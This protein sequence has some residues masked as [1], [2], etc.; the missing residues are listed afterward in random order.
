MADPQANQ[1]IE[2]PDNSG[3]GT[4]VRGMV[5]KG[6]TQKHVEETPPKRANDAA[7]TPPT[8]NAK[9]YAKMHTPPLNSELL[10]NVNNII[11]NAAMMGGG[12]PLDHADLA[13]MVAAAQAAPAVI[14]DN[15]VV[16]SEKASGG[17]FWRFRKNRGGGGSA[18]AP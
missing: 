6:V 11:M 5:V 8:A 7:S 4:T 15:S 3:A 2:K 1:S 14:Q 10:D 9:K 12:G 13:A 18:P 17:I 16:Q